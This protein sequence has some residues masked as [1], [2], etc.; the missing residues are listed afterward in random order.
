M[1]FESRAGVWVGGGK[2]NPGS[3]L[4]AHQ[5]DSDCRAL[6]TVNFATIEPGFGSR[7]LGG[8][9]NAKARGVGR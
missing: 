3:G 6:L 1:N 7:G 4:G 5:A 9:L 8:M 2:E